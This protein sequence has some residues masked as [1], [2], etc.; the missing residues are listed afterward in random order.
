MEKLDKECQK[1]K[2]IE[3]QGEDERTKRTDRS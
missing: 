1:I 3:R 2:D